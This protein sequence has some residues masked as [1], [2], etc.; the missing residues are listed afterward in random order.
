MSEGTIISLQ[1]NIQDK[2]IR[3]NELLDKIDSLEEIIMTYED[4]MNDDHGNHELTNSKLL[5]DSKLNAKSA[6][7]YKNKIGF[8][9]KENISLKSKIFKL[10]KQD[11]GS[12]IRIEE[13]KSPL[14]LLVNDLQENL[15]QKKK[16]IKD[17][18]EKILKITKSFNKEIMTLKE[19]L[20][21]KIRKIE[22]REN[23]LN[24]N[25]A[26]HKI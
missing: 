8:L 4:H 19:E 5:I 17:L 9:R 3:I 18:Q 10:E 22:E 15:N 20:K 2:N 1:K 23:K 13:K 21:I 11:V 12:I 25:K 7:E 6:R 14:N 16:I 26:I 24:T